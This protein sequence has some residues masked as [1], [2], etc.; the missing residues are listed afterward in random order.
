M[1]DEH[2]QDGRDWG[3]AV[4]D[5]PPDFAARPPLPVASGRPT[6]ADLVGRSS[7][8]AVQGAGTRVLRDDAGPPFQDGPVAP[9]S[10]PT[11]RG[12]RRMMGALLVLALLGGSA[13]AG[14]YLLREDTEATPIPVVMAA[15][16]SAQQ[17]GEALTARALYLEVLERDSDHP[18][19]LFNLG[20][21][22]QQQGDTEEA[23]ARYRAASQADPK[24]ADALFNEATIL[25]T[26]DR[27][28]AVDR[29]RRVLDLQPG[30]AAAH[31]NL[32][33]VLAELG[34][35]ADARQELARAVQLAPALR[36]RV[37]AVHAALLPRAS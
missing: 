23:L 5:D 1:N 28:A 29:Y 2:D 24:L 15:A 9:A 8:D 10:R 4:L 27:A 14:W 33:L 35:L 31:L 34:S 21:L 37:P 16:L 30:R 12:L 11:R 22:A 26:T 3:S 13:S 32:G 20:V 19:A 7:S 18:T 17:Q 6:L 25:A 36:L